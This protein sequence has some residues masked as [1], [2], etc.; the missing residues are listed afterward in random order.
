MSR[1]DALRRLEMA[2]QRAARAFAD[3]RRRVEFGLAM[4]AKDDQMVR[5]GRKRRRS[6]DDGSMPALVQPPRG[7]KPFAGGAAAALEFD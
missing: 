2:E 1:S 4:A 6:D 7:P 5:R 3:A